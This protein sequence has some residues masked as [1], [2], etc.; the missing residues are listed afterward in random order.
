LRDWRLST[1]QRT[2]GDYENNSN[3]TIK[4]IINSKKYRKTEEKRR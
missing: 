2:A 1:F 4:N 3:K